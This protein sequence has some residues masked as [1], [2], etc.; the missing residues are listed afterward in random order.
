[1]IQSSVMIHPNSSDH[2]RLLSVLQSPEPHSDNTT[3]NSNNSDDNDDDD[4]CLDDLGE[5]VLDRI[6]A[7]QFKAFGG[8]IRSAKG[9]EPEYGMSSVQR[10][11]T[12]TTTTTK[13]P[14]TA[15]TADQRRSNT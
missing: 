1:M 5:S 4:D 12:A 11:D 14:T 9:I 6:C 15:T 10:L 13:S 3:N 7:I 8:L 2:A